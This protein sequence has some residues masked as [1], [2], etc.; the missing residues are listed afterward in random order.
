MRWFAWGALP[1]ALAG[2]GSSPS[3][4]TA[5]T[6]AGPSTKLAAPAATKNWTDFKIQAARRIVEA[7]P[8]GV[9]TGAP[10]Q[11]LLAIPVLEVELNADGS[12]KRIEV[13]R[14]PGQAPETLQMAIDAVKRAAPF[15]D[16]SKLPKP[17]KFTEVFLFNDD[18]RFKPRTLDA[19]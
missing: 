7:N 18:K 10:Q 8:N 14:R 6:A 17:W 15:G 13:M 12:I 3:A 2:C 16:V 11:V 1:L 9:Y 5:P 19:L 4:P